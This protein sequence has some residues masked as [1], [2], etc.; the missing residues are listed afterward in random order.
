[1][2]H[3]EWPGSMES[4]GRV[5]ALLVDEP[6]PRHL[7]D[8]REQCDWT[9]LTKVR[10]K[11]R[12]YPLETPFREAWSDFVDAFGEGAIGVLHRLATVV[13]KPDAIVARRAVPAL[14]FLEGNGFVPIALD[15]V[16]YTPESAREEWRY[17][18]N[19]L[20]LDRVR[21]ST[22]VL[23]AGASL[24]VV[25]RDDHGGGV[26]A[27]VRLQTLKGPSLPSLHAKH[28]LRWVLRANNRVFKFVHAA[29]EPADIVRQLGVVVRATRRAD[30]LGRVARGGTGDVRHELSSALAK[31]HAEVPAHD[32]EFEGAWRRVSEELDS[33]RRRKPES[34]AFV[35][36]VRRAIDRCRDGQRLR[37]RVV[38]NQLDRTGA[39]IDV[40]DAIVVGAQFIHQSYEG[41]EAL[42][43]HSGIEAWRN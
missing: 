32:L 11:Q 6:F 41:D 24:L 29:D 33:V 26:P 28:H 35:A 1:M 17:Q 34:S 20:T 25:M 37:W 21:L 27:S 14:E 12:E 13:I 39:H 16:H 30:L 10:Q 15:P 9:A 36:D 18:W 38:E 22:M 7:V 19:Q 40:W 31:L 43:G 3:L 2:S 42:I 4:D 5:A 8:D 23:T